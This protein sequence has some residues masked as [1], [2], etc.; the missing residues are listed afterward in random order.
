MGRGGLWPGK[1]GIPTSSSTSLLLL[2]CTSPPSSNHSL[3]PLPTNI[4]S[5]L[6]IHLIST[7]L[8]R[9]CFVFLFC[10]GT[11]RPYQGTGPAAATVAA[12]A[13]TAALSRHRLPWPLVQL[14]VPTTFLMLPCPICL[15]FLPRCCLSFCCSHPS[16]SS[17]CCV[18]TPHAAVSPASASRCTV[19]SCSSALVPLVRL[20]V[21]SILLTPPC[22]I[23]RLHCLE[24]WVR[25]AEHPAS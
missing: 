22:P 21:E 18:T 12:F 14:V 9:Q 7:M 17:G 20:V 2:F 3:F 11:E 10:Q 8:N 24:V 4:K 15:R 5:F 6:I 25:A 13:A 19:V 23:C 1:N 16:C